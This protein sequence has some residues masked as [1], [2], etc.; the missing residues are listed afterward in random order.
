M[1]RLLK[2]WGSDS[3]KS[4]K[5]DV[6]AMNDIHLILCLINGQIRVS[7]LAHVTDWTPTLLSLAGSDREGEFDGVIINMPG[8]SYSY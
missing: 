4:L 3:E 7:S 5:I 8:F 2:C 6:T 1:K